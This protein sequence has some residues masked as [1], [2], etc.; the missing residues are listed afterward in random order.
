M[1]VRKGKIVYT[2]GT[3]DKVVLNAGDGIRA[4]REAEK[5]DGLIK[6]GEN[7]E[8]LL[9]RAYL[10]AKRDGLRGTDLEFIKWCDQVAEF[11]LGLTDEMIDK[12]LV[13]GEATPEQADV[14]RKYVDRDDEKPTGEPTATPTS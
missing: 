6:A 11:D 14:M 9:Y 2:D 8:L 5:K 13:S 4:K 12:M 7:D 10:A 3:S 1:A